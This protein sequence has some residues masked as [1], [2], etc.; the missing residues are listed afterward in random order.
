MPKHDPPAQSL[1]YIALSGSSTGGRVQFQLP[2]MPYPL[3]MANL[4]MALSSTWWTHKPISTN[5]AGRGEALLM[6]IKVP[7]PAL[8]KVWPPKDTLDMPILPNPPFLFGS[9]KTMNWPDWVNWPMP[10]N[11]QGSRHKYKSNQHGFPHPKVPYHTLWLRCHP[12]I[13]ISRKPHIQK[14]QNWLKVV[15]LGWLISWN[16]RLTL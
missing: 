5:T 8:Y 12:E 15:S 16:K 11:L 10:H 14:N 1:S 4:M 6:W 2:H 13:V 3:N 7:T 9:S